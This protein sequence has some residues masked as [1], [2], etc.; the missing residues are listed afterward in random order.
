[1]LPQQLSN[2][3]HA[4]RDT[5]LPPSFT[6]ALSFAAGKTAGGGSSMQYLHKIAVFSPILV[7]KTAFCTYLLNRRPKNGLISAR[8]VESRT[9]FNHNNVKDKQWRI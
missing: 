8:I 4:S 2:R 6:P 1:M 3:G 9:L 7:K 5:S